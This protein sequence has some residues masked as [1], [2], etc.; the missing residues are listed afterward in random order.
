MFYLACTRF[1][2]STYGENIDY[3]NKYKEHVIYGSPLKIREK[4]PIGSLLFVAEMNNDTN[5]IEGIGL[6]KNQLVCDKKHKIYTNNEYNYYIYRG[7]HWLSRPQINDINPQILEIFDT[8]LF[9]GKSHLKRG[10]GIG[11]TVLT[12]KIFVHWDYDLEPLKKMVK[13][14]FIHYFKP[15]QKVIENEENLCNE[16]EYKDKDECFEIIPRKRRRCLKKENESESENNLAK[17]NI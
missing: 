16:D 7:N 3:R 2:T 4:Y 1:N 8:V 14:L 11:I 5:M 15:I 17:E 10:G 9:K 6:I 12:E 13:S